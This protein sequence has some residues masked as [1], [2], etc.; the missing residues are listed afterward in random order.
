MR[1]RAKHIA[2]PVLTFLLVGSL[3]ACQQNQGQSN[4]PL[5]QEQSVNT[6]KEDTMSEL[7]KAIIENSADA[8]NIAARMGK[9]ALPELAS[10]LNSEDPKLRLR[11]VKALGLIELSLSYELLFKALDDEEISVAHMAMGE[12]EKK[13]GSLSTEILLGLLEK[14]TEPNAKNRVILMLGSRLTREQAPA[15]DKYCTT[16]Q[17]Q[18]VALH[19]MAALSKIG[20]EQRRKQL[21][22]YLLSIKEDNQAFMDVFSLIEYINQPWIVPSLRMLLSNKREVQYLGDAAEALKFPSF[23]RVCDKAVQLITQIIEIPLS[24]DTKLAANFSDKQLAEVNLA[25][26]NYQY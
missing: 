19:C 12:I 8:K 13:Q 26:S 14:V 20:M 7:T 6:K 9:A 1:V 18:M 3:W 5:A 15:L 4:E 17:P 2:K 10:L 11:S 23:L 16:E 22:A 21:S 25:V 24:F